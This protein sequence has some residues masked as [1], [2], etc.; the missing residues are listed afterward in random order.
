MKYLGGS[1][2]GADRAAGIK[3]EAP[4]LSAIKTDGADK[5]RSWTPEQKL[6]IVKEACVPS[7]SISAIARRYDLNANLLHTWIPAAHKTSQ[8][9]ITADLGNRVPLAART[10]RLAE[11]IEDVGMQ[12]A[13]YTLSSGSSARLTSIRVDPASRM[14]PPGSDCEERFRSR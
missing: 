5:R 10:A 6:Q 12:C 3:A 2:K 9:R 11:V 8:R 7:V 4:D 14:I 1:L 13:P